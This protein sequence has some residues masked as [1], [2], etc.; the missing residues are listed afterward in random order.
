[1]YQKL[2]VPDYINM[3]QCL[4]FLDDADAIADTLARLLTKEVCLFPFF[5]LCGLLSLLVRVL[6]QD[7]CLIAYQVAF[8]LEENQN[9]PFLDRICQ[10]LPKTAAEQNDTDA[11]TGQEQQDEDEMLSKLKT[12]LRGEISSNLTLHFLYEQ[13]KSDLNILNQIRVCQLCFGSFGCILDNL[14]CPG[15]VGGA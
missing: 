10:A 12:I 7:G 2:A 5:A 1:M 13:N 6:T 9:I 3:C 15:P 14:F 4:L 8:D 11:P